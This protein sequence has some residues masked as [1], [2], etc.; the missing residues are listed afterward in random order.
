MLLHLSGI[1][2]CCT[3]VF[4]LY[5]KTPDI[6]RERSK[7][8]LQLFRGTWEVATGMKRWEEQGN[9][10]SFNSLAFSSALTGPPRHLELNVQDK[11]A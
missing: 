5:T 4:R 7:L 6:S 11:R 2:E 10:E 1:W 9:N 8:D 3:R